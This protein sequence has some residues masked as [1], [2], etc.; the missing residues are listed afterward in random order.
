METKTKALPMNE[1]SNE[2]F[3]PGIA[4]MDLAH[5]VASLFRI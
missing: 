5:R 4:A 2:H 1:F 3:W